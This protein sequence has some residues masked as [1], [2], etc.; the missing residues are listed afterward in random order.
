MFP[1]SWGFNSLLWSQAIV[2]C[3]ITAPFNN[4]QTLKF[5]SQPTNALFATVNQM[6]GSSSQH[7]YAAKHFFGVWT[8]HNDS[9]TTCSA[10]FGSWEELP[11][12][13]LTVEKN[14]FVSWALSFR[15]RVL[16]KGT[17]INQ[18]LL[19][20][21]T[22]LQTTKKKLPVWFLHLHPDNF[23]TLPESV[24]QQPKHHSLP[25]KLPSLL[26]LVRHL[27]IKWTITYNF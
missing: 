7:P 9:I 2:F 26:L 15:V 18:L 17:V 3:I 5:K 11:N 24:A 10:V 12:I 8:V 1:L 20:M 14:A 19:L 27:K 13:W 22:F 23:V 21:V 16:L 25:H 6:F 4:M